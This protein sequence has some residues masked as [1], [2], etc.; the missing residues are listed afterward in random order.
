MK[1]GLYGGAFDPIHAG[2][3]EPVRAA[4]DQLGL[5]RV[6]YL[7]TARPPHKPERDLAKGLHR[8]VMVELALL[9]HPGLVVSPFE[10]MPETPAYTVDT[11]RHFRALHP[12]DELFLL[13]GSDALARFPTYREWEEILDAA[14][15]AVLARPGFD[16]ARILPDL[17]PRL[18]N[19]AS[20]GELAVV[21]NPPVEAS[22]TRLREILV[23]GDRPPAGWMDE[24]VL[25][26]ARKYSLYR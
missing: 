4:R 24:R 13:I 7:P 23:A 3:V 25:Q 11:I 17:G 1:I 20:S 10:L 16:V 6:V 19:L 5:D 22:S 21:H 12:N 9:D 8:Y 2:H 18:A 15:V 14:R 26:Y